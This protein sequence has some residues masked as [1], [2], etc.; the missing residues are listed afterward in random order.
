[1]IHIVHATAAS[2]CGRGR[3]LR[4]VRR[5]DRVAARAFLNRLSAKTVQARYLSSWSSLEGLLGDREAQRLVIRNEAQHVVLAAV[6]GGEIRGIGE[7]LVEAGG[8]AELAL[9]V[10]DAAQRR[11]IGRSLLGRLEQLA[12]KRGISAFTGDMGY[13]NTRALRLLRQT[14]RPLRVQVGYGGLR[15]SLLLE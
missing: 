7:F 10:E 3:C 8:V 14:G 6:E 9:V 5:R 12:R 4:V 15:F 11:G 1:L 2:E 13:A